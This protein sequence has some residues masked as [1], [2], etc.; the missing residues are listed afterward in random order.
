MEAMGYMKDKRSACFRV[1]KLGKV[2]RH[3]VRHGTYLRFPCLKVGDIV[4][5]RSS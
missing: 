1:D 4:R 2:V 5:P 3:G